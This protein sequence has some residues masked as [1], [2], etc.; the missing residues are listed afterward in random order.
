[1]PAV[2][3]V[4]RGHK[5]MVVHGQN[6]YLVNVNNSPAFC[7]KIEILY[8]DKEQYQEMSKQAIVTAEKF[9]IENSLN[10]MEQIYRQY[11]KTE[12]LERV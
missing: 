2:A 11:I 5:E 9:S 1:M 12:V 4:V 7:E 10:Q 3:S 8:N 6:G